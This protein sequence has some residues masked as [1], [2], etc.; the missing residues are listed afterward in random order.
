MNVIDDY[1]SQEKVIALNN[2][3]IE[4][5]MV[6]WIGRE[7][8]KTTNPLID[9]V[10]STKSLLDEPSHTEGATACHILERV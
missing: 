4:Y 10:M 3:H 2:L 9:L 6:H 5:A 1:L 7:Y 8:T